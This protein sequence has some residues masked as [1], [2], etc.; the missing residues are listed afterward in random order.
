MIKKVYQRK[1]SIIKKKEMIF[2]YGA[3]YSYYAR[4]DQAVND[5]FGLWENTVFL[6]LLLGYTN[7]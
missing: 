1:S 6:L 3:L 5:A 4:T 2:K 7:K